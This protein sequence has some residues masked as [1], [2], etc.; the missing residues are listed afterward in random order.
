M[1]KY[2]K[3]P[4]NPNPSWAVDFEKSMKWLKFAAKTEYLQYV[5]P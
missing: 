3:S 5:D 4:N 1:Q 2:T